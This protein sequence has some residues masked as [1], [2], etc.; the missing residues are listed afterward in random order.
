MNL[1]DVMMFMNHDDDEPKH[2]FFQ[3]Q[4]NRQNICFKN[5]FIH[6]FIEQNTFYSIELQWNFEIEL[7]SNQI[8][9]KIE[10]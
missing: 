9:I 7:Q 2:R 5:K 1:N 6:S 3:S 8:I 10:F 4:L